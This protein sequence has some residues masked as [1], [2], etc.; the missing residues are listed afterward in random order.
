MAQGSV[1]YSREDDAN[2]VAL[3]FEKIQSE[4]DFQKSIYF[5]E[6]RLHDIFTFI[7]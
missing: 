2:S 1:L 3:L 7:L 4:S 5:L 6:N